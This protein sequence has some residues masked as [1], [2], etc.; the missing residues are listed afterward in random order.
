MPGMRWAFLTATCFQFFGGE[1]LHES[2]GV[3]VARLSGYAEQCSD[4]ADI[5]CKNFT[6]S[7]FNGLF[8]AS[9]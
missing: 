4:G 8:V 9:F 1:I 6:A 3:L 7:Q 2:V 5:H